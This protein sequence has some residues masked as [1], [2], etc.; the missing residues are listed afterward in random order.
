[1][2]NLNEPTEHFNLSL[3]AVNP[4]ADGGTLPSAPAVHSIAD[5]DRVVIT[6][7]GGRRFREGETPD[8]IVDFGVELTRELT[9]RVVLLRVPLADIIRRV[10]YDDLA[11]VDID[12]DGNTGSDW[13]SAIPPYLARA[14]LGRSLFML[15]P[16]PG[17]TSGVIPLNFFGSNNDKDGI[18]EADEVFWV[19]V[20]EY[21]FVYNR[22]TQSN[23]L[24]RVRDTYIQ[25]AWGDVEVA[26][27]EQRYTIEDGD[28]IT[29]SV[30][31][32]TD[33]VAE[34]RTVR[35]NVT[36]E[37]APKGPDADMEVLYTLSGPGGGVVPVEYGDGRGRL[38]FNRLQTA[39][40]ITVGIPATGAL[41]AGSMDGTLALE[42]TGVEELYTAPETLPGHLGYQYEY[43]DY[44]LGEVTVSSTRNRA[45]VTVD[46][47]DGEHVFEATRSPPGAVA[48]GAD[49]NTTATWVITRT[50]GPDLGGGNLRLMWSVV[51]GAGAVAAEDADFAATTG[52]LTFTG[53]TQSDGARRLL[54]VHIAPDDLNE[55]DER[56]RVVFAAA[57][58]GIASLP[59]PQEAVIT[60]SADDAIEVSI[61]HDAETPTSATE[62]GATLTFRVG[63][64]GGIRTADVVVPFLFSGAGITDSDFDILTPANIAASA[65][66]GVATFRPGR[67]P[68]AD[69]SMNVVAQL[70]DDDLNE[71]TEMLTLSG[72]PGLHTAAGAIRYADG[73]GSAAAGILDDDAIAA[74]I[75]PVGTDFRPDLFHQVEEGRIARFLVTLDHASAAAATVPYV[76]SGPADFSD[77]GA[78]FAIED[79]VDVLSLPG[80]KYAGALVIPAGRTTATLAVPL[81]RDDDTDESE[82]LS[83]F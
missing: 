81:E 33:T 69:E 25:G 15:A 55:A 59:A 44:A 50:A 71:A 40:V 67:A 37:G 32:A 54:D 29:V 52:V 76:I 2:D 10:N 74:A 45:S 41:G 30:A 64:S 58:A 21:E 24:M 62:N 72:A 49:A 42:I 79:G 23:E 47:V 65:V 80:K 20:P 28:P 53:S 12:T 17:A 13:L 77:Y 60:D 27:E 19:A 63:L 18:N 43:F 16:V 38:R 66:S 36:L 35:F 1:G 68:R 83:V 51:P 14:Q 78:F 31:A 56:F 70:L 34:G 46:W 11:Q 7:G 48:E 6:L 82:L 4:A 22:A 75:I 5:N 8:L 3:E 9:V 61:T 26:V 57:D 39:G 73:A